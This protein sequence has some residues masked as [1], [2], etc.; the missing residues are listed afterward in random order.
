MIVPFGID[1][2][3]RVYEVASSATSITAW[4]GSVT[5]S[6]GGLANRISWTP[7]NTA[8]T[9][10]RTVSRAATTTAG[11][12]V[13][14]WRG[15]SIGRGTASTGSAGIVASPRSRFHWRMTSSGSRPR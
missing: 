15:D 13:R 9:A 8:N 4:P 5:A 3:R 6:V 2:P 7:M 11:E 1:V 14:P 10:I 12:N